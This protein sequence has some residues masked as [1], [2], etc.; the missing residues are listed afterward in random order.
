MSER[1]DLW[2]ADTPGCAGRIHLNNAGAALDAASGAAGDARSPGAGG[3]AGRLRGRGRQSRRRGGRACRGGRARRRRCPPHRIHVE[4]HRCVRPGDVG[5]RPAAW[6]RGRDDACRLH[7]LPDSVPV[8]GPASGHH[9]RPRRERARWRRRSA[10]GA[11][12][13]APHA[14]PPGPRVVDP[15]PLGSGPG[16]RG[17]G[18]GVRRGRRAVSG[19]RLPGGRP[20]AHRRRR[21]QVRL[22]HRHR[23]E[24][25]AWPARH[26]LPLCV[27][28]RSPAGRPSA[29]RRHARRHLGRPRYLPARRDGG[30]VR[31]VG[32]RLRAGARARRGGRVRRGR[33]NR[34][35][36]RDGRG[37]SQRG[38]AQC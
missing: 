32:V 23:P 21:T 33:G 24:V 27:G 5:V 13:P 8:A 25:P 6:R 34:S 16:R 10:V 31:R 26:R 35:R 29:L 11:R 30:A 12:H 37:G 17:G 28:T 1:L 15:H 18:R 38:C 7:L 19:R 14:V 9:R 2:R 20:D 22:P 36:A 4:R 3:R